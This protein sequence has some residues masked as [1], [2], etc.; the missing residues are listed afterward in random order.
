MKNLNKEACPSVT[1]SVPIFH[2]L[3]ENVI[4]GEKFSLST[5]HIYSETLTLAHEGISSSQAYHLV[6]QFLLRLGSQVKSMMQPSV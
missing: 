6:V 4:G 5:K 3:L 1:S 2:Y